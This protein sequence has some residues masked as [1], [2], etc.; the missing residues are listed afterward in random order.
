MRGTK[1]I[2]HRLFGIVNELQR[3]MRSTNICRVNDLLIELEKLEE[4][5]TKTGSQSNEKTY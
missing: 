3:E 4:L 1:L 5:G 2:D